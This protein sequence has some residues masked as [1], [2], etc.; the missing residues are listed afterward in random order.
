MIAKQNTRRITI[1]APFFNEEQGIA[2]FMDRVGEL[3][4]VLN[5][6]GLVL[7]DDGSADRTIETIREKAYAFSVPVL[8]V[9]LSRNF[10]HQN[11]CM[12]GLSAALDWN[13]ERG[14]EWIGLIDSD[15]Q[16][17]PADLI[18]LMALADGN[19][20]VYAQRSSREDGTL[21]RLLAPIFY[22]GLAF[23]SHCQIPQNAGVFSVM[24]VSVVEVL[25][26]CS[27]GDPYL[28]GLRAWVGFRQAAVPLVR[29]GRMYGK[30]RLGF[31]GLVRL[32]M[33]A[34]VLYTNAPLDII[35]YFGIAVIL[36][37]LLLVAFLLVPMQL[38]PADDGR[39][40]ILMVLQMFSLGANALLLGL[41]AHL[42]SR[43]KDN[44]TKQKTWIVS[45]IETL[46]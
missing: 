9:R 40:D 12:A 37:S 38:S 31:I 8:L 21:M 42:V 6:A 43:V 10:G 15:L 2:D 4:G 25:C 33:R 3:S 11:A 32:T 28:P 35:F 27:D 1:V 23:F 44:T 20:V 26:Q 18:K 29:R 36:L 14:A 5:L 22:K 41:V 30:S 17:D 45:H 16:D 39:F 46:P 24:R 13:A 34:F 7:V 19:D